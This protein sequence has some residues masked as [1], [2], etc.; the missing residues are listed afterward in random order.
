[1]D[2]RKSRVLL[3]WMFAW[4]Y[5]QQIGKTDHV[6]WCD[7]HLFP[8]TTVN[9]RISTPCFLLTLRWVGG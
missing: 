9:L 2:D 1:M 4:E 5:E 3:P 8:K 6:T 7:S